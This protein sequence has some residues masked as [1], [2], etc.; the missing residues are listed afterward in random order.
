MNP[1]NKQ[2]TFL[3]LTALDEFWDTS[4]PLLLLNDWCKDPNRKNILERIA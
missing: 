2:A 3:A 1:Q 4:K